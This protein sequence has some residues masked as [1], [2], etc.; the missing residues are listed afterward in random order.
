MALVV[1]RESS[2]SAERIEVSFSSS[3]FRQ[4]DGQVIS[5]LS[6]YW[7]SVGNIVEMLI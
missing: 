7:K 1:F 5:I 2:V 3:M 4:Y 6:F